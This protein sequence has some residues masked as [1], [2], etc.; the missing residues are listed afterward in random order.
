MDHLRASKRVLHKINLNGSSP[1]LF[2]KRRDL[3]T[4]TITVNFEEGDPSHYALCL[5]GTGSREP[6]NSTRKK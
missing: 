6:K 2:K 4:L 1:E 5:P 3:I